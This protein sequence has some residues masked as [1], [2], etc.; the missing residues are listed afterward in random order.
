MTREEFEAQQQAIPDDKLVEMA[1]NALS[2]LCETGGRSLIMTVPPR[3]DD[4]DM[5]ISEL[6]RRFKDR[7][8][9]PP[10]EGA[11]K[12]QKLMTDI[13]E[14]S[15]KT[16]GDGQRNPAIVYHLKKEVNELIAVFEGNPRN[17]HRQLWFEYADCLMLLLDSA[18]HAGFT[19]RDLIDATREKLEINKTRKWGKPDENGVIEQP[20]AEGAEE[21]AHDLDELIERLVPIN[22]AN[23]EF[24]VKQNIVNGGLLQGIRNVATLHAQKIAD[25]MVSERLREELIKYDKYIGSRGWIDNYEDWAAITSV[26]EYL[27][28][29]RP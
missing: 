1:Q 8:P 14:W 9:L 16:F 26:D 15:N 24:C 3:V 21:T 25:K 2:K 27:K 19:A 17:A 23:F 18:L 6:I 5:I 28:S 12:L 7:Q 20:T 10:A 22:A 13:S 11:E 29:R 4:T